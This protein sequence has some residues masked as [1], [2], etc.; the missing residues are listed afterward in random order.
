MKIQ[1]DIHSR[2]RALEALDTGDDLWE[3]HPDAALEISQ[4]AEYM[5]RKT[6]NRLSCAQSN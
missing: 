5:A 1:D 6:F 4:L 2:L 3:T